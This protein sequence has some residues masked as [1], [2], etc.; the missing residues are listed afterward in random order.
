LTRRRPCSRFLA[1]PDL[2][3]VLRN[4]KSRPACP[5][6]LAIVAWHRVCGFSLA[7]DLAEVLRRSGP[8]RGFLAEPGLGEK[9]FGCLRTGAGQ[10][11]T[12]PST[13]PLTNRKNLN[14]SKS[15]C[16]LQHGRDRTTGQRSHTR[17]SIGPAGRVAESRERARCGLCSFIH[18][19]MDSAV[20]FG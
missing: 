14:P 4:L 1:E 5:N 10:A 20:I 13:T 17:A 11:C 16:H 7:C 19:L 6:L 8:W 9:E 18:S 12:M 2:H 3:R 15:R